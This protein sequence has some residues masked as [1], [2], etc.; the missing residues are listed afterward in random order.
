LISSVLAAG[1]GPSRSARDNGIAVTGEG[2][3]H[4]PYDGALVTLQAESR[5]DSSQAALVQARTVIMRMRGAAAAS[6]V[7]ADDLGPLGSGPAETYGSLARV[8]HTIRIRDP[9]R[10]GEIVRAALEASGSEGRLRGLSLEISDGSLAIR[11]AR[12]AALADALRAARELAEIANVRLGTVL[13]VQE[14]EL[15]KPGSY[16]IPI[17]SF[18]L[19]RALR[20]IAA[21][22]PELLVRLEVRYSI[23]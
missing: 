10:I 20:T 14:I 16:R 22:P 9:Q 3:V 21:L 13:S 7:G 8:D 12:K 15:R 1:C 5:G 6:G 17:V 2:R 23:R 11:E 18:S 4:V 19:E